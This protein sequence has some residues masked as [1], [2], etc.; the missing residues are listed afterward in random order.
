MLSRWSSCRNA[1]ASRSW[2]SMPE[3]RHSSRW[4]MLAPESGLEQPQLG[5]RR[6]TRRPSRSAPRARRRGGRPGPARRRAR[7]R[8]SRA[9]GGED[10]G[11][12]EGVALSRLCSSLPS[13]ACAAARRLDRLDGQRGQPQAAHAGVPL[14]SPV[15]R[16][17]GC[18]GRSSSSRYVVMASAARRLGP[19]AEQGQ[20]V[21]R[22][23][24][25]PV[26]VL[27]DDERRPVRR[28]LL[29]Q[30]GE[31]GVRLVPAAHDCLELSAG[32]PA[33]CRASGP[34]GRGVRRAS[35]APR[36]PARS[37]TGRGRSAGRGRSSRCPPRRPEDEASSAGGDVRDA[38]VERL[39]EARA[40]EER[41]IATRACG[42]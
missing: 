36:A 21:E 31:D 33:R 17:S 27:E 3:L 7:S 15:M 10:L 38:L 32:A 13:T 30:G 5:P 34:S 39:E 9:P 4:A 1:T 26:E 11:D 18:A 40:F 20:D 37:G 23:L 24:V 41:R 25:R 42:I 19:A 28:E 12:E 2:A 16:R 14:I 22:R 35:H 29:E 6:R 8:A